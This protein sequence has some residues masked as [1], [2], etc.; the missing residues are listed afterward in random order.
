MASSDRDRRQSAHRMLAALA[1]LLAWG[2]PA[3]AAQL[4]IPPIQDNTIAD[5]VD[6][7]SGE[8]FKDNSSG[9]CVDV[10]SGTTRGLLGDAKQSAST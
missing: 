4:S 5:G 1:A 8:D 9:A 6:P 7:G 10:F 2:A 3:P